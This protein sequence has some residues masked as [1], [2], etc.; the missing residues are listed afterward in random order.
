M[1]RDNLDVPVVEFVEVL[2]EHVQAGRIRV[3]GGSNWSLER[4]Q[5]ANAYAESKG[6][7]GFGIV[8][9]NFSLARMVDPVWKGCIAASE[10]KQKAWFEETKTPLLSWSSQARG[11]FTDRAG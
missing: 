4:I 5:E 9:N 3:F 6:L 7:Q 8:S 10:A 2:N 11:F 1:H